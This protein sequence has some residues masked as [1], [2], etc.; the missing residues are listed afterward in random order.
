MHQASTS[1][2]RGEVDLALV[3][4]VN[5]VLSNSVTRFLRSVGMLSP[6]GRCRPFDSAGD[7]YVRSEG[8]G[9]VVLKRLSE[10]QADGDRIWAVVRGS[11]V[12]QNGTSAGLTVPN[13]PA[14]ERVMQEALARAGVEPG[15]VDYM[16]AHGTGTDLGDTIE[17]GA[18]ASA[19]G[20]NGERER[21]LLLGSVKSN[22]GHLEWA[23]GIA[24]LIKTALAM[25]HGVIPQH[26]HFHDPNPN[27]D[28]ENLPVQVTSENVAWPSHL[29]RAPLAG[30]HSYGLS[31]ANAHVVLEGYG[32]SANGTASVDGAPSGEPDRGPS[33]EPQRVGIALQ[34]PFDGIEL[35]EEELGERPVRVLPLSAKS[36]T[37]LREMAG[38]HLGGLA[39]A[40][41]QSELADMAWTAATGRSHFP[42]R[43]GIV[44]RD[45]AQLREG[46]AALAEAAEPDDDAL[47]PS[48]PARTAFVYT[49]GIDAW[50][51]V[52]GALYET[53]P[54]VRAVLD[55][56]E[57]VFQRERGASLLDAALGR[58]G[59]ADAAVERAAVYAAQAAL[60]ALWQSAGLRPIAALGEGTGELAA[61]QAA[62]VF[63]LEDG[64]RL[65]AA[66]TAPDAALPRIELNEP[67]VT[68]VSNA[69]GRA[70]QGPEAADNAHW[71][72]LAGDMADFGTCVAALAAAGVDLVVVLGPGNA[73]AAHWPQGGDAGQPAI[74]KG[75]FATA[76]ARAYEAGAAVA[77]EALFSGETRR[78]VSLPV[79]PFERRSFWVQAA[80]PQP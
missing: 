38:E 27:V 75:G 4:G 64:L 78:R 60:T 52:A 19:Y 41:S 65:A 59:G 14:Q 25:H 63:S 7:G 23:S 3:G 20:G 48:A 10:A 24:G 2:Q 21:P 9:M 30:V 77:F 40:P 42:Y 5:A 36:P 29:E 71:R 43:S 73:V 8:C 17:I 55:R 51:G 72:K 58:S 70:L 13:G 34:P 49:G 61:A 67:A 37:A 44:F 50:A 1:L 47:P 68:V 12:N 80:R 69:T 56:C 74:I 39:E 31:G 79:Y 15:T 32:T 76:V 22:I 18:I 53:E 46:L 11:A 45:A 35:P 54:V 6:T 57:A 62:G 16:E 33:G 28:W 66:L 26:L